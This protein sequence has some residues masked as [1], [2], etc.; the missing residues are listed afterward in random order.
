MVPHAPCSLQLSR[1][2]RLA[3]AHAH[4]EALHQQAASKQEHGAAR[5]AAVV[6]E[7]REVAALARMRQSQ[8]AALRLEQVQ[9]RAALEEEERARFMRQR[10]QRHDLAAEKALEEKRAAEVHPGRGLHEAGPPC[11]FQRSS[12]RLLIGSPALC[13]LRAGQRRSDRMRRGGGPRPA[14]SRSRSS[15]W[16]STSSGASSGRRSCSGAARSWLLCGR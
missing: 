14:R 2:E 1:Q 8:G 12:P 15:A 11:S 10:Q 5:A 4:A 9:Q 3:A 7:R 6:A 13:R 16:P